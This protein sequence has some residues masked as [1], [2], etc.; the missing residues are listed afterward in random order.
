MVYGAQAAAGKK[1]Y[2]ITVLEKDDVDEF[3]VE[4]N[5]FYTDKNSKESWFINESMNDSS[6]EKIKDAINMCKE[7]NKN[8]SNFIGKEKD[9]AG[10]RKNELPSYISKRVL[11]NRTSAEVGKEEKEKKDEKKEHED[12]KDENKTKSFLQIQ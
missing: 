2:R 5:L 4:G 12:K 3:N 6:F 9:F 11:A 7:I 10:L 8:K 1:K